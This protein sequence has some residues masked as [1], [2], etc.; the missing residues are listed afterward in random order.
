MNGATC[1]DSVEFREG[2]RL[3]PPKFSWQRP[4]MSNKPPTFM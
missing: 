4:G 1:L 2:F 3:P